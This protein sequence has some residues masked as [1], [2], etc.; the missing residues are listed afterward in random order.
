MLQKILRALPAAMLLL[1]ALA[2]PSARAADPVLTI[3]FTGNTYGNVA[4]CP[5]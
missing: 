3:L 2:V 1:C 5:S 4:P